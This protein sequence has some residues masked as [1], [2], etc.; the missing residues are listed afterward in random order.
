M[1]TTL[2][3]QLAIAGIS[4]GSIYALVALAI[5]IPFKASGVLNFGQGEVV[6]FGAYAA[7]VLTQLALPYPVVLAS[8]LV[9]GLAGG[10]LVER[11]LIRP[12]VKAPEFTLVIATFAI[13]L[14]IK[15]ALSLKF[16]D[17]PNTIDGPFGSEPMVAAGLRFNPTSLWIFA[18]TALVTLLVIVFFRTTRL[19][20]AMRAVSVNPEAARLMGIRVETVYRWSWGI[21]TAIGALAGLLVAPL[22]GINPE[23]GQ[24]ILRGLLGAVI[25]GFTSVPGAIVGGLAVGLIETWSGVLVGSAF[26]NL[27]PF[28]LL[29][30]LLVFRPQGLFGVAEVKRV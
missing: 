20:K 3:V 2:A 30:V 28:L 24:L 5:V 25:G 9:L 14:L 6:T 10:I 13:G 18:C 22:I 7:L 27:V 29:M 11:I 1:T 19:G 17:S 8:V 4:V 15:G 12:I 26:K 16:G 21:S 23:I